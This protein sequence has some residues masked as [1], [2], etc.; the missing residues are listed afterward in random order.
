MSR[1]DAFRSAADT[2][3]TAMV[4]AGVGGLYTT[5]RLLGCGQ[6]PG[7][8]GVF[9]ASERVGGRLFSVSMPGTTGIAKKQPIP[10]CLRADELYLDSFELIVKAVQQVMPAIKHLE[11]NERA[12]ARAN[13]Q[14]GDRRSGGGPS[15]ATEAERRGC[16]WRGR[17][18]AMAADSGRQLRAAL[19]PHSE[20]S[21]YNNCRFCRFQMKILVT[22]WRS[23][24]SS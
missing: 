6:P 18:A 13:A 1:N 16:Y 7:G 23:P 2:L 10:Y 4:G 8:I 15:R 5:W 20:S 9:E 11:P 24:Q 14:V 12:K 21:C 19:I 3:D 17:A 22:K